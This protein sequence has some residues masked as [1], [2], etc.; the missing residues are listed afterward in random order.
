M[1]SFDRRTVWSVMSTHKI[2]PT[3]RNVIC[4][5][6]DHMVT[7]DC[8]SDYNVRPITSMVWSGDQWR[9][10]VVKYGGQGQSGQAIKLFQITHY[11]DD[12]QTLN[13]PGS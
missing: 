3:R 8:T 4:V 6:A 10:S 12:F 5:V 9:R 2:T 7:L 11:V 1:T 13:N